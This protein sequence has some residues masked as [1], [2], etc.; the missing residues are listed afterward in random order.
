M[1]ENLVLEPAKPYHRFFT[2]RTID[3]ARERM[4]PYR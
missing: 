2:K 1:P 4:R 3:T